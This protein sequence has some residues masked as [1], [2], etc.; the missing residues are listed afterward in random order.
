MLKFADSAGASVASA[1]LFGHTWRGV[2][3]ILPEHW[4]W[5]SAIGNFILN[6]GNL[7]WC[8]IVFLEKHVPPEEFARLK[9]AHFKDRVARVQAIL[10]QA[11]RSDEQK[12]RISDFFKRLHDIRELRN[13]I[14]HGSAYLE[15]SADRQTFAIT[16]RLPRDLDRDPA[17]DPAP[18]SLTFDDLSRAC[19]DLVKLSDEFQTDF[20][21][22][23]LPVQGRYTATSQMG[24]FPN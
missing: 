24:L 6:F 15:K 1:S 22:W 12:T 20:A 3:S 19:A 14:A 13:L 23:F 17:E 7:D 4:D 21:G 2:N 16:M 8:L 9:N 18:R 10:T 11:S 5:P